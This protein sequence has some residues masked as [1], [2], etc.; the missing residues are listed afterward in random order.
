MACM[1]D[2][3]AELDIHN[4]FEPRLRVRGA[5]K[6]GDE[7]IPWSARKMTKEGKELTLIRDF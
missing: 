7:R 1:P 3:F 2:Q 5:I 6:K 4:F